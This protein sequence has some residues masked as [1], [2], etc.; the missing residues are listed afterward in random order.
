[1]SIM[2]TVKVNVHCTVCGFK[3]EYDLDTNEY[4]FFVAP[5]GHCPND[6]L[7]LNQE[8]KGHIKSIADKES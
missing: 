5:E 4:G 3:T 6:F 1:M 7:I 2:K 8:I